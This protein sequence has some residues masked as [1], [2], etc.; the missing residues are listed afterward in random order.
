MKFAAKIKLL[1]P[2]HPE[3]SRWKNTFPEVNGKIWRV[4]GIS[5]LGKALLPD[6]GDIARTPA[7]QGRGMDLRH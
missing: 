5:L 3:P 4:N 7:T 1:Q 6:G 2:P